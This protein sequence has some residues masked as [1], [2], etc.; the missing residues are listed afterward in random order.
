MNKYC[1]YESLLVQQT[2]P[3]GTSVPVL[4]NM[5]NVGVIIKKADVD[6]RISELFDIHPGFAST[7]L[8][9]FASAYFALNGMVVKPVEELQQAVG[10]SL[11]DLNTQL[12]N[13]H[14]GFGAGAMGG[15]GRRTLKKSR[16][17]TKNRKIKKRNNKKSKKKKQNLRVKK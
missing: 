13:P 5:G 2:L 9:D 11:L 17:G 16:K 1:D 14:P 3:D 8:F 6:P 7:P 4:P 15:N 10:A 12:V